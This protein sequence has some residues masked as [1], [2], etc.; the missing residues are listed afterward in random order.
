LEK[1]KIYI[2]MHINVA[3]TTKHAATPPRN[4]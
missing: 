3:P 4:I 2:K 1:F